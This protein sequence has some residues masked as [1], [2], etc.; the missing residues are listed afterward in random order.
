MPFRKYSLMSIDKKDKPVPIRF[1]S[2]E[3]DIIEDASILLQQPKV[4]TTI[5][6]LLVLGYKCIKEPKNE[7]ILTALFNNKRK[8]ERNNITL[9]E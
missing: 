6:F 9:Y 2:E 4:S 8:N 1:N 5:K 3:W 7:F